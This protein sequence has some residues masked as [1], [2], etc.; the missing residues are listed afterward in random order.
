MVPSQ[1][2]EATSLAHIGHAWGSWRRSIGTTRQRPGMMSI[3]S[4]YRIARP[5]Q[6]CLAIAIAVERTLGIFFSLWGAKSFAIY[7]SASEDVA[8]V[9]AHMWR[10]I[11]WCYIFYAM[12]T[13]MATVLL[14]T[15]PKWYLWQS[16]ANNLLYVLP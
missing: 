9:T 10:T 2:L 16:L 8:D 7:L 14:A 12:S 11:D 13:Q 1:S 5:A 6:I 15:R 3:H 4:V